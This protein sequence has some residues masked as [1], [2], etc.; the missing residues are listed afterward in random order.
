[1]I[2][3]V[4]ILLEYF[5]SK[6]CNVMNNDIVKKVVYD[7]LVIKVNAIDAKI[8]STSGLVTKYSITQT[9]KVLK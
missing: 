9:N 4:K 5:M 3:A 6:G 1:M 8:L 2:L 7:K